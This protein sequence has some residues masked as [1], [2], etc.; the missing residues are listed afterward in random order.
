MPSRSANEEDAVGVLSLFTC[1][2]STANCAPNALSWAGKVLSIM[3][4]YLCIDEEDAMRLGL[5]SLLLDSP[6]CPWA[7]SRLADF[8]SRADLALSPAL[9]LEAPGLQPSRFFPVGW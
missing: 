7:G 1:A 2:F 6:P 5:C 3:L 8:R 9:V 4:D